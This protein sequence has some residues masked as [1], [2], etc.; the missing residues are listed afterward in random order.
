[1]VFFKSG[2]SQVFIVPREILAVEFRQLA[3]AVGG[4]IQ[5]IEFMQKNKFATP[6]F[7]LI[8]DI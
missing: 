6:K 3:E 1:M 8:Q 7:A 4:E 5:R 2:T